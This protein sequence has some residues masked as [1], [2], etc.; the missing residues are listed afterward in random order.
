M[1]VSDLGT[2]F[3]FF[4][5]LWSDQEDVLTELQEII[6]ILTGQTMTMTDILQKIDKKLSQVWPLSFSTN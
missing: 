2:S 6:D 3:L 5:H 4:Q 1:Y